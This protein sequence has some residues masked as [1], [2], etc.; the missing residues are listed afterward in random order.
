MI[1]DVGIEIRAPIKYV[2]Y[3]H[4]E[5]RTLVE[6]GLNLQITLMYKLKT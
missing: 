1:R 4:I 6:K 3:C 5:V 2:K